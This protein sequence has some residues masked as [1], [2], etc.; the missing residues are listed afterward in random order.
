MLI[1][2]I[3]A[4]MLSLM[5]SGIRS[6]ESRTFIASMVRRFLRPDGSVG[7]KGKV[8]RIKSCMKAK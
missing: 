3:D 1:A 6:D 4:L 8:S 7:G 2:T 5:V